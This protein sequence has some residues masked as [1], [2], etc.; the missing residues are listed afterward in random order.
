MTIDASN[1]IKHIEK[2]ISTQG[3]IDKIDPTLARVYRAL[4][5]KKTPTAVS[6]TGDFPMSGP[7]TKLPLYAEFRKLEEEVGN[8]AYGKGGGMNTS[9]FQ[10]SEL[11]KV[12]R[13][14]E[15]VAIGALGKDMLTERKVTRKLNEK[16]MQ[17]QATRD[18]LLGEQD[19][20]TLGPLFNKAIGNASAKTADTVELINMIKKTPKGRRKAAVSSVYIDKMGKDL[21]D[22]KEFDP[23]MFSKFH[24]SMKNDSS[25]MAVLKDPDNFPKEGLELIDQIGEISRAMSS[26]M[27]AKELTKDAGF[28][29][30]S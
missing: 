12:M 3:G 6:G 10:A 1:T 29:K 18:Y 9:Q 7:E 30:A 21:K 8:I 28:G 27:K 4:K 25:L 20:K 26:S 11:K 2:E 5:P 15:D 24:S 13:G 22:M 14:D 16:Y 19:V 17:T 23:S